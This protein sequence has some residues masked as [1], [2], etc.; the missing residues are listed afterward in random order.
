MDAHLFSRFCRALTPVIQG[1]RLEKIQEPLPGLLT[2]HFFSAGR[3]AQLCW[4]YGKK[5][6]FCF[7]SSVRIAAV[8]APSA[9]VMRLRKYAVGRRIRASVMQFSE[10]RLWL[11]LGRSTS[12]D[13]AAGAV[14]NPLVWLCLDLRCGASP[15]FLAADAAPEEEILRW[16]AL[17]NLAEACAA[18][19][20]W[21][22]LT[23][24]LR[25]TLAHLDER[26]GLALLAD[27]REGSGDVFVY[28]R[29]GRQDICLAS[30]WPLPPALRGGAG[31]ERGGEALGLLEKAGQ[32]LVLLHFAEQ[33]AKAECYAFGRQARKLERLRQRLREEEI[34]LAAMVGAQA[35]ALAL[36]EN[37]WRLPPE[38]RGGGVTVP[39]GEHGPGRE[40][41]LAPPAH[42]PAGNGGAFS[43][44]QT[45][46]TRSC[47][48][49]A[50]P[51]SPGRRSGRPRRG[52][53]DV[54]VSRRKLRRERGSKKRPC[55]RHSEKSAEERPR[56]CQR[57][58]LCSPARAGRRG[59]SRGAA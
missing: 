12:G 14:G 37:L 3:A 44:G 36:R 10:R 46:P 49:G 9:Q 26:E 59:Q 30:A 51:R 5:D 55:R 25:R 42:R 24:A 41:R 56:I 57:R 2:F 29:P 40:I 22:V 11:L 53:S 13:R 58:R 35:D 19:R 4:R 33:R 45:R 15:H 48:S 39:A 54:F 18:W 34:R 17:D 38:T 52:A 43:H 28:R 27:L 6:A 32:G 21:P 23:P 47:A 50:A 8:D 20:Q 7:L 1:A 16:P 31:E